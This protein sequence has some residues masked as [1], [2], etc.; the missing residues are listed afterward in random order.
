LSASNRAVADV[1]F[2]EF[3]AFGLSSFL[4][5]RHFKVDCLMTADTSAGRAKS[6][7]AA[8]ELAVSRAIASPRLDLAAVCLKLSNPQNS[9]YCKKLI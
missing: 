7:N 8:F 2:S 1:L 4:K 9:L 5:A 3:I 6:I